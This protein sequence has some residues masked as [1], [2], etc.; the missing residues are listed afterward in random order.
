VERTKI[1]SKYNLI[2][3]VLE[4]LFQ[5]HILGCIHSLCSRLRWVNEDLVLAAV[6]WL[7]CP[8]RKPKLFVIVAAS[9]LR[10]GQ[11]HFGQVLV[12]IVP[13]S[14]CSLNYGDWVV[15]Q[16]KETVLEPELKS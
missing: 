5:M 3:Y 6:E 12:E 14:G 16:K 10:K 8:I 13:A 11:Q 1:R 4:I 9:E 7:S 15:R 2:E